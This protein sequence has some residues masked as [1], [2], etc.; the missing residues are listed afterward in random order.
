MNLNLPEKYVIAVDGYSSCGKSTLAKDLAEKLNLIYIDT[1]A[2]Y[3]AVT[4]FAIENDVFSDENQ[5]NEQLLSEKMKDLRIIFRKNGDFIETYLND[6]NVSEQIRGPKVSGKVSLISKI[7]FVRDKMVSLQRE[8]G[9]IG[10][11]ILDGRDIGTVVFPDA[12]I[13]IFMTASI[14]VRTQRRFAEMQEK[15][16]QLS[17]DE[18]KG[19]L[20]ERDT[21]DTTR[22]ESPLKKAEDAIILDN[23]ELSRE[24]QLNLVMEVINKN[25]LEPKN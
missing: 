13:K 12:E 4:L 20:E 15:Y 5:I 3:R 6:R 22:K 7:K 14:Q 2:M 25:L 8:M 16:P 18:V 1:G 17:L 10:K 24:E 9:K 21:I 19:N 23:S 11:V